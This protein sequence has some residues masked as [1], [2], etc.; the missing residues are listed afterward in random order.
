MC[1]APVH[2]PSQHPGPSHPK[3]APRNMR[4]RRRGRRQHAQRTD[5][6]HDRLWEAQQPALRPTRWPSGTREG[7]R[8]QAPPRVHK[9]KES[10]EVTEVKTVSVTSSFHVYFGRKQ[11]QSPSPPCEETN[12][13]QNVQSCCTNSKRSSNMVMELRVPGGHYGISFFPLNHN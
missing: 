13:D 1:S 9:A 10:D 11:H 4:M 12:T 2:P 8:P 5:T 6:K 7:T 3:K